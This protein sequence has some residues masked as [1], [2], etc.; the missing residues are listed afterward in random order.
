MPPASG[1]SV[2]VRGQK[3]PTLWSAG[4]PLSGMLRQVAV[5]PD[6]RV[7]LSSV[8]GPARPSARKRALF[9]SPPAPMQAAVFVSPPAPVSAAPDPLP[10]SSPVS[11]VSVL[12]VS[13]SPEP[14]PDELS[15]DEVSPLPVS[16]MVVSLSTAAAAPLSSPQAPSRARSSSGEALRMVDSGGLLR[17]SIAP[18]ILHSPAAAEI[19]RASGRMGSWALTPAASR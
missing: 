6:E 14:D 2:M 13:L 8:I 19:V 18:V 4:A 16:E 9:T 3:G 12:P 15:A 7:Q 11:V 17:R 5:A 10:V 1:P